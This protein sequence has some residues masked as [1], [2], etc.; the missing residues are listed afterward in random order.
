MVDE[1]NYVGEKYIRLRDLEKYTFSPGTIKWKEKMTLAKPGDVLSHEYFVKF[2]KVT[3]RIFCDYVFRPW[4]VSSFQE[5]LSDFKLAKKFTTKQRCRLKLL[6]KF[7]EV[8]WTGEKEGVWAEMMEWGYQE[9]F[10]LHDEAIMEKLKSNDL[11]FKTAA[12]KGTL[13]VVLSVAVGIV[14][15][16]LLKEIYHLPYF[17][18]AGLLDSLTYKQMMAITA[19][20]KGSGTVVSNLQKV[21]ARQG[22]KDLYLK[23]LK[24]NVIDYL[25]YCENKNIEEDLSLVLD[26]AHERS[27]GEGVPRSLKWNELSDL[28]NIIIF[29]CENF[30]KDTVSPTAADVNKPLSEKVLTSKHLSP[31]LK[32]IFEDVFQSLKETEEQLCG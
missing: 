25:K 23:S 29:V 10:S 4:N 30:G 12:F 21:K 22:E 20:W 2:E 6:K 3:D 8:Y 26:K 31:G 7:H 14:E 15:Y 16:K 1:N 27:H 24:G 11:I 17:F 32:N 9:Y 19:E 18:Y 5:L 13:A 28:E